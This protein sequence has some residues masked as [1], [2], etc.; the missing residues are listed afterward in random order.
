MRRLAFLLP[1]AFALLP[2]LAVAQSASDKAGAEALFTDGRRLMTQGNYREACPKFEAS[3]KLDPAVGAMLNLADCYEKNGQTASAWAEF[4]EAGAAARSV[5]S[6]EREELARGR[7]AA[8]EPK[9]SRLTIV[10][11]KPP[12][13]V[14]RDG[15]PV[16]S[17]ALGAAMPV[18]PGK[19]V[20]EATAKGKQKWSKSI[21]VAANAARVSV[22]IP[23][24]QDEAAATASPSVSVATTAD[25]DAAA[26][27]AGAQR[28]I[29]IGVG[30]V[31]LVGLAVG[32]VFGLKASSNWSDAKK[33]CLAPP[34]G[35]SEDARNLQSDA[36]NAATLSTVAFAVGAVG[37]ISGAVLWFT[38]PRSPESET[39]LSLGVGPNGVLLQ[40]GF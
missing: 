33:G 6:K 13:Q 21:E 37:A 29:A 38:A 18:D 15:T 27:G 8:L 34:T 7:A 14:T 22:E 5:G 36:Q 25:S 17:A 30:A 40:G 35:C 28:T 1:S 39:K 16:D 12:A 9:L 32:T 20:I 24:L 31:G 3:L 23:P 19:H 26:H 11:V 2:S 4:R 10:V